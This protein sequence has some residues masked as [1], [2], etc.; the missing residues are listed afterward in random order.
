[1]DPWQ[2]RRSPNVPH[3]PDDPR[4]AFERD[5]SR[6]IHSAAF[7]RLQAKTQIHGVDENDFYRTRL[8]HSMEVAQIGRGL[9]LWLRQQHPQ[10][11]TLLP[12]LELIET[13]GLAHDLGH[14]PFGHSGEVALHS[15]MAHCG[16][17]EGNG[18]SL[19]LL[20]RLESHTP[21]HGLNL[22]RRTLLGILKYP[23]S[24]ARLHCTTF[25]ELPEVSKR[26]CRQDGEPP[27]GYLDTET[28]IVDWLLE[29]FEAKERQRFQQFTPPQAQQHGC[30][31]HKALDT[32]LMEIADDIAYG[33][34]DFEDAV[35]LG[36]LNPEHW[37]LLQERCDL[38]WL[39]EFGT[40]SDKLRDLVFGPEGYQRKQAIGLM[41]HLLI[42]STAL[43]HVPEFQHCLLSWRV[44]ML[45][46]TQQFLS[47]LK[48]V[49]FEQVIAQ[50]SV[51]SAT[52]QG[53]QIIRSLFE[54]YCNDP[55]QLLPSAFR[56]AWR[57]ALTTNGQFRVICD[58][59]SGMTDRYASRM[60]DQ[61][62][63]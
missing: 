37:I 30:S 2:A 26:I 49:V 36:L 23:V 60:Y 63:R 17:F 1:M 14:A 41:V 48:A 52:F 22:T 40:S 54:A 29:P 24:L 33:V 4:P 44:A 55:D 16:G 35:A 6:I 50:P 10:Q 13:I 56:Q 34:H 15:L 5:R 59:L 38:A 12:G 9:V 51:Q 20:C 53:Q 32:S 47:A 11:Q 3:R 18:Q 7:R 62:C 8:T 42:H 28:A 27:K 43:Q 25:P 61:L 45:P 21:G 39:R 31:L 46:T 58:Y 19:R 57:D